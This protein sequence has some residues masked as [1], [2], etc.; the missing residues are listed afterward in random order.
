MR[1]LCIRFIRRIRFIADGIYSLR[2]SEDHLRARNLPD[3]IMRIAEL[4]YLYSSIHAD[5]ASSIRKAQA[6]RSLS[7][8][9]HFYESPVQ[10]SDSDNCITVYSPHTRPQYVTPVDAI[11]LRR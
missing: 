2:M 8:G 9:S 4:E 5:D 7:G 1:I 6:F 11:Q 10:V 3:R